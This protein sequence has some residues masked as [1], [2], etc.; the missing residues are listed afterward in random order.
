M[1]L[2]L[3]K[4]RKKNFPP[5]RVILHFLFSQSERTPND[6]DPRAEEAHSPFPSRDLEG[7]AGGGRGCSRKCAMTPPQVT[8]LPFLVASSGCPIT[9]TRRS[10]MTTRIRIL[11]LGEHF[12]ITATKGIE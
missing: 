1:S 6:I 5:F 2:L 10:S 4:V 9:R 8:E 3:A 11:N 12:R 7:E